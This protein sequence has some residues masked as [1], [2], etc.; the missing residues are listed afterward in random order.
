LL[1]IRSASRDG[2][3]VGTSLDAELTVVDYA[4]GCDSSIRRLVVA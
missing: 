4:R 1:P 2:A 3:D